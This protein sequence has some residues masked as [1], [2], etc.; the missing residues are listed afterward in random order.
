MYSISDDNKE[1][2][3]GERNRRC[4]QIVKI[5]FLHGYSLGHIVYRA[6]VS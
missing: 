4:K 1:N 2:K 5:I 6:N 3:S